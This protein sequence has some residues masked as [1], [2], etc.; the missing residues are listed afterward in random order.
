MLGLCLIIAASLLASLTLPARA[1]D[2]F[3]VTYEVDQSTTGRVQLTGQVVNGRG[4]DVFDVYVTAEALDRKGRMVASGIAY[5][6][7]RINRGDSRPFVV[8]VP[9]VAGASRYR[10]SVTSFRSMGMQA[11]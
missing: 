9:A 8:V 6:E 5:V 1:Q 4:D 7:G 2:G 3:S 11:P 10:V